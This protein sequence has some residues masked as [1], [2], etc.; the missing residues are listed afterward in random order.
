MAQ[1]LETL[2]LAHI[3]DAGLPEP[4]QEY[5]FHQE[6][7]WRLDFA[8]PGRQVA[9]EVEG[10][11]WTKGRHTRPKGY[12]EDCRKYSEAAIAG[13]IVIRV[14]GDM[15]RSGVAVEMLGRA[16]SH[17]QDYIPV[18]EAAIEAVNESRN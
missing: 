17:W 5:P 13:W 8:W 12:A 10:G 18:A 1:K 11:T 2:I 16:L 4:V 6:R 3:R 7:K 14:T 15:I 9:L